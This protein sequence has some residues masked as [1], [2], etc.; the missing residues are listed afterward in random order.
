MYFD[1]VRGQMSR[2]SIDQNM[3]MEITIQDNSIT[4]LMKIKMVMSI[5]ED[6]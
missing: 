3:E 6:K 5:S 1:N 2:S 4:Q